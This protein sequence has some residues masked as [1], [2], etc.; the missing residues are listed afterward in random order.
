[1]H[2]V[3][4]GGC[5]ASNKGP[6]ELAATAKTLVTKIPLTGVVFS[7]NASD[8]TTPLEGVTVAR[9]DRKYSGE[10]LSGRVL[11]QAVFFPKNSWQNFD[12]DIVLC[13]C[14]GSNQKQRN[15][16]R[17]IECNMRI[18]IQHSTFNTVSNTHVFQ[19][20]TVSAN[21]STLFTPNRKVV[22]ASS[23]NKSVLVDFTTSKLKMNVNMNVN[24]NRKR[25]DAARNIIVR[26]QGG[27]GASLCLFQQ[28][29][30]CKLLQR[31]N[32]PAFP[33]TTVSINSSTCPG[34]ATTALSK[35][36]NHAFSSA[37]VDQHIAQRSNQ[38]KRRH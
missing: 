1:M 2:S 15:N 19:V 16:S 10:Q 18:R 14:E 7:V 27:E 26:C 4:L 9:N 8:E 33:A 35:P 32:S 28:S 21:G 20:V 34:F 11:V 23:A 12:S 36:T 22:N 25:N 29:T 30:I 24:V 3:L 13:K 38:R 6:P 17:N 31:S 37:L 5:S